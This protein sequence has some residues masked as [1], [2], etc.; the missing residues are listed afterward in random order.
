MASTSSTE[1]KVATS[2]D[3]DSHPWLVEEDLLFF[4]DGSDEA[5]RSSAHLYDFLGK[6]EIK[7]SSHNIGRNVDGVLIHFT[8]K[9]A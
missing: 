1:H 5:A 8:P 4:C 6:I 3:N 2:D 7:Y 9:V